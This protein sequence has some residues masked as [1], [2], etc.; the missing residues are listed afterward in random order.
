M[1]R[2]HEHETET[3]VAVEETAADL[4]ENFGEEDFDE[5]GVATIKFTVNV[6]GVDK[7]LTVV[8]PDK[9]AEGH[10]M[11]GDEAGHY[12]NFIRSRCTS[13]MISLAKR[14]KKTWD[15]ASAA[16]YYDNYVLGAP[17]GRGPSDEAIRDEALDALL[18][19]ISAAIG[20]PVPKGKGS[21]DKR[22]AMKAHIG[23][24]PKHAGRLA[25]LEA[26][27]RAEYAAK[28]A[29][30]VEKSDALALDDL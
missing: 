18:D 21:L 1:S 26:Q 2:K 9:Y 17:R 12:S 28:A 16:E 8:A 27:V 24:S 14:N 13:N 23:G 4:G 30:K 20:K 15:E 5:S 3:E 19:E 11:T 7:V 10:V 22:N 6:D 29:V 25:E